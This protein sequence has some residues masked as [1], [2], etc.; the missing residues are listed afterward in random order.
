VQLG[1]YELQV[2]IEPYPRDKRLI[3]GRDEKRERL[4]QPFEQDLVRGVYGE[5]PNPP[6]ILTRLSGITGALQGV[7]EHFVERE[8]PRPYLGESCPAQVEAKGG[9]PELTRNSVA[10]R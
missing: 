3:L 4:R 2:V 9:C 7:A 6:S 10:A 1:S 5:D 8:L